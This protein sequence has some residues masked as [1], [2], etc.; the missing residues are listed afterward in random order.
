[1]SGFISKKIIAISTLG[2]KLQTHRTSRGMS[3]EDAA[4][5]MAINVK[6]LKQLESDDYENLPSDVY[7]VNILKNYAALLNLN[8]IMV[9]EI[10]QKEKTIYFGTRKKKKSEKL[11]LWHKTL[12]VFLNPQYLKYFLAALVVAGIITYIGWQINTIISPPILIVDSPPD[13]LVIKDNQIEIKGVTEKEVNLTV[14]N[15]TVLSDKNGGFSLTV[16][17]QNGLNVIKIA[18]RKKH[19]KEQV[20][21]RRVVVE[22]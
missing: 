19:S 6:Y 21:Y 18:A 9:A 12:N 17:L 22:E 13:N 2:E 4:H 8:P 11:T 14:N 5:K 1:M 10:Y 16:D 7:S 3:I 15:R 20:V